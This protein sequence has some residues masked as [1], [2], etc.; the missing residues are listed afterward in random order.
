MHRQ[1]MQV[2]GADPL[3]YGVA[4][5]RAMLDEALD[6]AVEQGI[7]TRRPALEE[8]FPENLLQLTA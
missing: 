5:N 2:T 8:L 7:L 6:S 3:P 1:V 4:P